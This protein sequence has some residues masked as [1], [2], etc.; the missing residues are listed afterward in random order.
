MLSEDAEKQGLLIEDQIEVNNNR[1]LRCRKVLFGNFLILW[2]LGSNPL[3]LTVG[4][5]N[6]FALHFIFCI[7][8]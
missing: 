4:I 2:L 8:L 1:R 3:N 5:R 6:Q 7:H